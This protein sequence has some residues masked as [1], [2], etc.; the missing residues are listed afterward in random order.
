MKGTITQEEIKSVID[1]IAILGIIFRIHALRPPNPIVSKQ[2]QRAGIYPYSKECDN[3]PRSVFSGL[4]YLC[5]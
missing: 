5:Q 2:T 4:G 3:R 1:D